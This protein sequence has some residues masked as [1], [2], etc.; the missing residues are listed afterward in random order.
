MLGVL[1]LAG[2]AYLA[3]PLLG[4]GATGQ[5]THTVYAVSAAVTDDDGTEWSVVTTETPATNPSHVAKVT[6]EGG[7]EWSVVTTDA[8]ATG[9]DASAGTVQ[10]L[11][12]TGQAPLAAVAGLLGASLG[13]GAIVTNR[14]LKRA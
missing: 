10:Q 4:G 5:R 9:D 1:A 2:V 13:L 6:D 3:A 11:P 8:Q 12:N 14:T 7:T